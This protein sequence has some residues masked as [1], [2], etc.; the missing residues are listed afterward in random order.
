M[1]YFVVIFSGLFLFFSTQDKILKYLNEN[2]KEIDIQGELVKKAKNDKEYIFEVKS[3]T[4]LNIIK[5]IKLPK[6]VFRSSEIYEF[7]VPGDIFYKIK[8]EL[9]FRL[10][11][12]YS[13]NIMVKQFQLIPKNE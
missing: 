9:I 7:I 2:I 3:N 13:Q 11:H 1:R 5:V 6:E 10:G 4:N 12:K 8:G